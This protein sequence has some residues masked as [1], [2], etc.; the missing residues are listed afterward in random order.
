MA[1]RRRLRRAALVAIVAATS[2]CRWIPARR[3]ETAP[4]TPP[5]VIGKAD[6]TRPATMDLAEATLPP[7][8]PLRSIDDD[9][10]FRPSAPTPLLDAAAERDAAMKRFLAIEND[11]PPP[12]A[13]QKAAVGE[14]RVAALPPSTVSDR[15]GA[16]GTEKSP[17]VDEDVAPAVFEPSP[18]TVETKAPGIPSVPPISEPP[19]IEV[20]PVAKR[21]ADAPEPPELMEST[22]WETVMSALA[23]STT[24]EPIAEPPGDLVVT[25]VPATSAPKFAISEMR[26]CK[27]VFGFGRTEPPASSA[28]KAGQVVLLYCELDG[29]RDEE[30]ADGFRSRL[31][32]TVAIVPA[33][34]G[35]PV[36]SEDLGIAED[37]CDRRRRDFFVNFRITLPANLPPGEY[38][39]RL[40]QKDLLAGTDA[41]RSLPLT[42]RP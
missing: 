12:S 29:V 24:A 15:A 21:L 10:A 42:V 34:G 9:E 14:V 32:A 8:P 26:I 30:T 38:Q 22:L 39:I 31:A 18:V 4:E 5:P 36:W 3:G 19:A 27:R 28:C 13:R 6:A 33:S 23:T 2:G 41:S 40:T 25:P 7:L 35:Q 17:K 37:H 11:A 16:T 1:M 20:V